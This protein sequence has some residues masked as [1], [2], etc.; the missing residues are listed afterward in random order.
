[1]K[2]SSSIPHALKMLMFSCCLLGLPADRL[3]LA[4]ALYPYP[5][6]LVGN[7]PYSLASADF[8]GD[9]VPDLA[10][11]NAIGGD[12]SVL[13]GRGGGEFAAEMRVSLS[14]F[15]IFIATTDVNEDGRIDMVVAEFDSGAI[16]IMLGA[17]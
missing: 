9:G 14:G 17:G 11:A 4:D 1:M 8:N 12:I 16:T 3:L 15:P 5:S 13:L 6:Y 7:L 2:S 10:V